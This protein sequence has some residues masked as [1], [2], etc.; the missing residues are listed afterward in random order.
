MGSVSALFAG[1]A[2]V[3]GAV[4]LGRY[5]RSIRKGYGH[6]PAAK[7]VSWSPGQIPTPPAPEKAST[8]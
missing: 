2:I 4:W 1:T 5:A 8:R 3:A 6:D 7:P